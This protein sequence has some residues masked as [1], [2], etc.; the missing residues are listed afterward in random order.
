MYFSKVVLAVTAIG[1]TAVVANPLPGHSSSL[2][3][4]FAAPETTQEQHDRCAGCA[5]EHTRCL[6]VTELTVMG[7]GGAM[8]GC[9]MASKLPGCKDCWLKGGLPPVLPENAAGYAPGWCTFHVVQY[10]KGNP[11][12]DP[13]HYDIWIKDANRKMVGEVKKAPGT[14]PINITSKLPL[15]FIAES[16]KEDHSPIVFKYGDQT[17]DSNSAQCSFGGYEDGNRDGDCG[18]TCA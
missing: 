8:T 3:R 5:A 14:G 12:V 2:G 15:V 17:F 7:N 6:A 4:R 18:F 10:Q 13:Y 1:A 11:A 16:G 9:L